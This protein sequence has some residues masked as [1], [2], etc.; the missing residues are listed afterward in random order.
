MSFQSGVSSWTAQN[1]AALA[2]SSAQ[3]YASAAVASALYSA[4]ITPDGSTAT[5]GAISEQEAASAGSAYSASAWFYSAAGYATGAQV[6]IS[7]YNSSHTL[8]STSTATALAIP[9]ATWTQVTLLSQAAPALTAYAAV[10]VQFSGTPSA[11]AFWVAE[12]ALVSGSSAVS[13][14][15]VTT[16]VPVRLRLALGTYGGV[17]Y[18][19]WYAISRNM[20]SFSEKRMS[21]A[22]QRLY[23]EAGLTDIWSVAGGS[24]PTPYRGEVELDNPGWWWP[25]DDQALA[26]GV[27]PVTL[28]NAATGS[29]TVLNI[30][31][32]PGGVISQDLYSSGLG[33]AGGGAGTDLTSIST[34]ASPSVATYA[35]AAQAGWM[36]GDPQVSPQSAQTGNPVTSQPGSAAWQQSGAQGNTGSSGW[37]LYANDTFPPIASGVT[38]EGW[39]TTRSS[40]PARPST[41]R[42]ALQRGRAA[43]LR[44]DPA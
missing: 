10:T 41:T 16:G 5:P 32:A 29:S 17:T 37:F 30:T 7:W 43:V 24:C 31:P 21:K 2:R 4:Q 6:A 36:Y 22:Y 23:V 40:A 38:V 1:G 8:I 19:R 34:S 13:T 20:A 26:G 28:R 14:G 3:S 15:R 44:A 35:V 42:H 33:G 39:W 27:L 25:C 18:N 11:T 12:A 9:A